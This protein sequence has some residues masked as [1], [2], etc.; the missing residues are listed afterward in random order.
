ML[1][2][3]KTLPSVP[4]GR[5]TVRVSGFAGDTAVLGQQ[6]IDVNGVDTQV[7]LVL[8]PLP[9]VSGI[10]QFIERYEYKGSGASRLVLAS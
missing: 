10:V 6:A 5:Y 4:P 2:R 7:D 3:D 8:R 1:A 9:S